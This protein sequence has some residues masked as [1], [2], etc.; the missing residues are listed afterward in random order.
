[1][2]N[3]GALV[4]Q[5]LTDLEAKKGKPR[6]YGIIEDLLNNCLT[7][8]EFKHIRVNTFKKGTLRITVDSSSWLYSINLKKE[9]IFK[10]MKKD[11]T[12]IKEIRFSLGEIK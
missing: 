12:D 5:L 6:E 2:E 1:M 8:Q 7:K 3:I 4:K 10:A 9:Q 11:L